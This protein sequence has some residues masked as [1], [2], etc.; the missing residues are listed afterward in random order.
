[1]VSNREYRGKHSCIFGDG[2]EVPGDFCQWN[3]KMAIKINST[4][5][6]DRIEMCK[7][8]QFQSILRSV[9]FIGSQISKSRGADLPKP[10]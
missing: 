4:D 2:G 5:S 3:N 7:T 10:E 1:M 9:S 6:F 8:C